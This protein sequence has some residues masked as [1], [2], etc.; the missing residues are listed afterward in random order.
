M[1]EIT[2]KRKLKVREPSRFFAI[3]GEPTN[4]EKM[5]EKSLENQKHLLR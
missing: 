1:D 4:Y 5:L 3:I 2:K